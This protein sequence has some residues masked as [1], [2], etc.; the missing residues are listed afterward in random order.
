MIAPDLPEHAPGG[1]AEKFAPLDPV[2]DMFHLD[3]L[4][5]SPDEHHDWHLA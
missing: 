4:F 1:G 3:P 2:V 5:W